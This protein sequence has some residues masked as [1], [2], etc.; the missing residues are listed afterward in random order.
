MKRVIGDDNFPYEQS[1]KQG[2]LFYTLLWDILFLDC[3]H[4]IFCIWC[5]FSLAHKPPPYMCSV[6]ISLIF[7]EILIVV[8]NSTSVHSFIAAV[9]DTSMCARVWEKFLL[10]AFLNSVHDSLTRFR[11][12]IYFSWVCKNNSI[13]CSYT[14]ARIHLNFHSWERSK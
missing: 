8:V 2:H 14:A 7:V 5:S 12:F 10:I 3:N 4:C 1:M 11:L 13:S 6:R 9:W